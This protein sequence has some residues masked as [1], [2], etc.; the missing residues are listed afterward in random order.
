[1]NKLL[2]V[3]D[4]AMRRYPEQR[5]MQLIHNAL[6]S[7]R[8]LDAN[9]TFYITDEAFIAALQEYIQNEQA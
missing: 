5:A 1:M 8:Q 4:E 9:D 3:L 7:T 6:W 2:T